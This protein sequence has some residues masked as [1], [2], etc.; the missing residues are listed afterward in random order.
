V[1]GAAAQ[2]IVQQRAGTDGVDGTEDDMPYQ[3]ASQLSTAGVNTAQLGNY[4][5]VRSSTFE[6]HVTA[7]IGG[8][9]REYVAILFRNSN[10][11]IQILNFCW[12]NPND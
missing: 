3:N 7:Q 1:D 8:Y 5:T 10:T 4:C 12:K 2:A 6:V 11:D 9:S